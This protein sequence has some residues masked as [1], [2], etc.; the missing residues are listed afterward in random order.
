MKTKPADPTEELL[1][2]IHDIHTSAWA[3]AAA[4]ESKQEVYERAM[5]GAMRKLSLELLRRGVTTAIMEGAYLLWWLRIACANHGFAKGGF[6]RSLSRIG[7]LVRPVSDI[8]MRLGEEIEDEGPM[9]EMQRL[10]EKLE[11]LRSLYGGAV[12]TRPKSRQEEAVQTETA[13]ALIQQTILVST[14]AGMPP[15]VIE[16]MLLYSWFR[17]TANSQGLKEA[18]FQKIE[19]HWDLVMEHVNRYMD[20]QAAADRQHV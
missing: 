14:D 9:P 5:L 11:E 18:F 16:S 10:G 3:N 17:C 20:D 2:E 15:G 1:E 4:P 12:A 13:H 6:D 8:M 19:R 7:P